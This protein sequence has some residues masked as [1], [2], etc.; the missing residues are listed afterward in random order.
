MERSMDQMPVQEVQGWDKEA[1]RGHKIYCEMM[2]SGAFDKAE[3]FS[4][5]DKKPIQRD[6]AYQDFKDSGV[7]EYQFAS[8]YWA[9]YGYSGWQGLYAALRKRRTQS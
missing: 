3:K 7:T 1:M 8:R 9:N 6:K 2:M 5:K 4:L